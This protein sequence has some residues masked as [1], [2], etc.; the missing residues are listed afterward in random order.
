MSALASGTNPVVTHQA[1]DGGTALSRARRT[2]LGVT[3][4]ADSLQSLMSAARQA[5]RRE[6][7]PLTFACANPHSL[8]TAHMDSTFRDILNST[9]VVVADGVGIRL[10]G[11]LTRSPVGPRITGWDYFNGVMRELDQLEGSVFLLGSIDPVLELMVARSRLDFPRVRVHAFSPP[12]G[13][14]SGE[15][16]D[17]IIERICRANVD[18]LWVGM[19]AP[20]QE[21]WV[22]A[23]AN[24][25]NV[26]VTGSIGA[27]FDYYAGTIRRAPR[28]LCAL[29][30]EWLY[31]LMG[32]PRRLWRRTVI[33]APYFLWLAARERLARTQTLEL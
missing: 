16:N 12:F 2:M 4:Q 14:W 27:V 24:R 17:A 8:V 1:A 28:W 15:Q 10:A 9:S 22:Y 21:R 5:I 13:D 31:R 20:R 32:E 25:L 7:T 6:R 19:T 29:G 26:A 30:L 33:S 23:N 18:V 11:W 3:L